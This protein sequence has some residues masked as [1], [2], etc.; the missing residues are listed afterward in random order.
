[1]GLMGHTKVSK[2]RRAVATMR[3]DEALASSRFYPNLKTK[4]FGWKKIPESICYSSAE[5]TIGSLG[6]N[7]LIFVIPLIQLYLLPVSQGL[8]TSV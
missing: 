8:V 7:I 2:L 5:T 4:Y 3:Q 1:M 6:T